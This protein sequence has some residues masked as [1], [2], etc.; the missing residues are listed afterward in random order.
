MT[1]VLLSFLG[2]VVL[3]SKIETELQSACSI[4]KSVIRFNKVE[5]GARKEGLLQ[6]VGAVDT[7]NKNT[8]AASGVD[9]LVATDYLLDKA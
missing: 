6:L 3:P 7:L 8:N 1:S 2:Q 4:A 9:G 5:E